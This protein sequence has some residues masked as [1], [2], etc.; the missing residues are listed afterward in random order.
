MAIHATPE[1]FR[2]R[3][4]VVG[5]ICDRIVDA[6]WPLDSDKPVDNDRTVDE[7]IRRG[8]SG[9]NTHQNEAGVSSVC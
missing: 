7:G 9:K 1:L 2:R 6:G 8:A 4:V 3:I 5:T